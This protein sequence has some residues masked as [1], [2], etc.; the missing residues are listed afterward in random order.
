MGSL[1]GRVIR[2][3]WRYEADN[4]MDNDILGRD[5]DVLCDYLIIIMALGLVERS[6]RPVQLLSYKKVRWHGRQ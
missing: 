6:A 1:R 4:F 3:G 2:G 5:F